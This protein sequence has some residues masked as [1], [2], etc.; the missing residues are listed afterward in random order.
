[1]TFAVETMDSRRRYATMNGTKHNPPPP[2]S[3][4]YRQPLGPKNSLDY[5]QK[6]KDQQGVTYYWNP[7]ANPFYGMDTI[8]AQQK[9]RTPQRPA[10]FPLSIPPPQPA[11][12]K[13]RNVPT[14]ISSSIPIY[15]NVPTTSPVTT[16]T[17]APMTVASQALLRLKEDPG[18]PIG[19]GIANGH[20]NQQ[21]TEVGY[22]PKRAQPLI[23]SVQTDPLR[24]LRPT[25]TRSYPSVSPACEKP[26]VPR[27]PSLLITQVQKNGTTNGNSIAD[28]TTTNDDFRA[29][30]TASPTILSDSVSGEKFL[31]PPVRPTD[32]N[33]KCLIIDLDETLVHSS[34]KPV[35]NPD[36]VIPVEIDGI[37]HQVYVLKRPYV[38]EFLARIGDRYE[39]VLFTA[40]LAKYADPVADLLDKRGV[41]RSR[42]FREACVYHKGNY[43]KDLARL[44]RDLSKVLIIDNSP[45]SYSF[46]PENAIPVPT[47]WDDPS[48]VELLDILPLLERLEKAESIY[49]VLKHEDAP[50]EP[51]LE[52]TQ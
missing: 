4:Q 38:D 26:S 14:T 52:R 47:W 40:S 30:V 35:K 8:Y 22:G 50:S 18:R 23:W 11:Q 3:T 41:F 37:V 19:V 34:F 12:I 36:F 2:S 9:P 42:L 16:T 48:D 17:A 49:E 39:C 46:H 20:L 5:W 6:A 1:M 44:G 33:K 51:L 24:E 32:A 13:P 43:V 28:A 29:V 25:A 21:R 15:H 27:N 10:P 31:L 7:S 45:A